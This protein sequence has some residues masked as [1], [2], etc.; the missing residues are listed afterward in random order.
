MMSVR[1]TQDKGGSAAPAYASPPRTDVK[2]QLRRS[3]LILS[4]SAAFALSWVRAGLAFSEKP[5]RLAL[6]FIGTLAL[7]LS[8][9]V[10]PDR[11]H[12]IVISARDQKLALIEKGKLVAV[13]PVSTSKFGLG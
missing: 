13:Y 5:I 1:G 3:E 8:S 7:F 4:S 12:H 6:S 9:C 10:A 11:D 2:P